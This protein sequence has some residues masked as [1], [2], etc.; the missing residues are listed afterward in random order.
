MGHLEMSS[1]S[2]LHGADSREK[3]PTLPA[4]YSQLQNQNNRS[5]LLNG[6]RREPVTPRFLI[7]LIGT[8][9]GTVLMFSGL[10]KLHNKR[11]FWG[12]STVAFGLL[13]ICFGL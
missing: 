13:I 5:Y 8:G 12:S 10:G 1:L 11:I 7:A 9:F 3:L 4:E 2:R 6:K